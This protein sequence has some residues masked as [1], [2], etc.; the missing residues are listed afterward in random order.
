MDKEQLKEYVKTL[1]KKYGEIEIISYESANKLRAMFD[2]IA[3]N[4]LLKILYY[5]QIKWVSVVA[6]N[7]LIQRKVKF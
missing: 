1:R 2:E 5:A 6:R 7:R 4:D 3:D